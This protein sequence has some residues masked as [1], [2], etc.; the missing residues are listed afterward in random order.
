M[1]T[2]DKQMTNYTF[3]NFRFPLLNKTSLTVMD[4]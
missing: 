4:I 3:Y 2:G 1:G